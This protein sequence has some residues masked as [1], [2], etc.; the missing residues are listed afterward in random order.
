MRVWLDAQERRRAAETALIDV[1]L[2]Q[3]INE[4]LLYRAL[5]GSTA[6]VYRGTGTVNAEAAHAK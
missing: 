5:G 2:A 4:S 1:R 3:I 6:T